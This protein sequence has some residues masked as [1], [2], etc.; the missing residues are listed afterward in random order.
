[1]ISE[2]VP[3]ALVGERLDRVVAFLGDVSRAEAS[4]LIANGFVRVNDVESTV[5]KIKLP[6]EAI[7]SIDP[8]GVRVRELPQGDA[9]LGL[10]VVHEDDDVIVINKPAGLVVHPAPGNDTGTLVNAL[11]ARYPELTGV[12][13]SHR[14]GIVHRLDAGTSG[15]MIVARTQHAYV[16]LLDDL[17]D[18]LVERV[19]QALVWGCPDAPSGVVDAP[20]GRDGK[21][22]MKMAVV[23][24][25]KPART[26]YRLEEPFEKPAVSYVRCE[27]ESG[28][29]HQIRVH[30][31]AIGHPVVADPVYGG[32]RP[33]LGLTRP[34]LHAAELAF[35]HPVSHD[36]LR[37]ATPLTEDLADVLAKVRADNDRTGTT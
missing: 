22:S 1:V 29:T 18:H 20:I 21:D 19:Y 6:A 3:R 23:A 26:R 10:T 33:S 16:T 8:S 28:R 13:E 7:V 15:L 31:T 14:P 27:L 37:F 32:K 36:E 2:E 11:L 24:D 5:G 25:G 12:G 17:R 4:H 34:F 35:Q 9:S 30:M